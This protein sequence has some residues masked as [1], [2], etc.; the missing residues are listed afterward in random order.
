MKYLIVGTGGTGGAVGGFLAAAGYDV[1]FIA[2]GAHLAAMQGKGLVVKSGVRGEFC[3]ENPKA[4]TAE[5]YQDTPDVAFV[6]VKGY[7]LE[8]AETL[9]NRCADEKTIIIPILNIFGTGEELQRRLPR[10]HVLDG[11]I[12]ITSHVSGPGEITQGGKLFS[13]VFGERDGHISPELEQIAKELENSGIRPDLTGDIRRKCF[14]K[15]ALISAMATVGAY[16]DAPTGVISSTPEMRAMFISLSK[17]I[18]ALAN[19]MGI[20]FEDNI[21]TKNLHL[22]DTAAPHT[23]ASL[24]KDLKKGKN[25]EID[26][27]I[28]EPVR[29]GRRYHVITPAFLTAAKKFGFEG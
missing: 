26:G 14:Q 12:Y 17:E 5:D 11:C 20:P 29:L 9:L 1:T 28:F 10:L 24:Q 6:C 15:Y 2:R 19:A 3:I 21:V 25:S 23:T 8:D 18:G 13:V 4:C 27:L 16:Y 22:L 7:S